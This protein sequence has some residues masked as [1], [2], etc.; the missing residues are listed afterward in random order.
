MTERDLRILELEKGN[1]ELND[2]MFLLQQQFDKDTYNYN[3]TI[4]D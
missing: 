3:N 4:K 2:K 1:R